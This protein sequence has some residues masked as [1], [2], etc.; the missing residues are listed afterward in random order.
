MRKIGFVLIVTLILI[1][2]LTLVAC[3]KNGGK[4]KSLCEKFQDRA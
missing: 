3:D 2:S 1:L 4:E